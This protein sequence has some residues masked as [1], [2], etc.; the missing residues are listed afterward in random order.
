MAAVLV[1]RLKAV[2]SRPARLIRGPKGGKIWIGSKPGQPP[3]LRTGHGRSNITSRKVAWNEVAVGVRVNAK[4]MI[5]HE[6]G[7]NYRNIGRGIRSISLARRDAAASARRFTRGRVIRGGIRGGIQQR[8][9]LL[10][11]F[12]KSRQSLTAIFA[13]YAGSRRSAW[14]MSWAPLL[15]V[16]APKPPWTNLS[17]TVPYSTGRSRMMRCHMQS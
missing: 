3:M 7:I 11:T 12:L 14:A 2:T 8:P 13:A 1:T 5:Y 4:Y 17:R 15:S 9:W 6:L 16:G 10:P